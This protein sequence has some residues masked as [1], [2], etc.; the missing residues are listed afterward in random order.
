MNIIMV[1]GGKKILFLTKS[2]IS[3][4]YN[5]TVINNDKQFCNKLA[6]RYNAKIVNGDGTKLYIL[7]DAGIAATDMVLALTPK[8]QDNL[9][10]CQLASK[11][12]GV[13]KTLA[14]VNDPRNVEVFDKL[15]VNTT[16]STS[17]IISSL[18]EQKVF[19]D[20]ITNLIPLEE[21]KVA[22][23]ELEIHEDYPVVNKSL[24]EIDI[25]PQAIISCIVRNGNP[26]I[27]GGETKIISKDKVVILTL[28][29]IQSEVLKAIAGRVD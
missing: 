1:G 18:I 20:Q 7:E 12:F 17:G 5:V 25:P 4:G 15:G 6:K 26:I 13:K 8:D 22:V 21:G 2:F 27:P 24:K 3:K 19:V 28:P 16:I 14:L 10:T 23:I 29:E 9:V 11:L